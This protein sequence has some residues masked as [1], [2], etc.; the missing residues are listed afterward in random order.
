MTS[1]HTPDR[2][3]QYT[4]TA[5]TLRRAHRDT[6]ATVVII[7]HD[8][9]AELARTLAAMAT[10]PDD[11]P[12]IV[13][14]NGSSD[15]TAHMVERRFPS[16]TVIRCSENAGAIG[17]N[18]AVAQLTT[19]YV[20]FCDDDTIWQPGSLRRA[21]DL[22][23]EH[24]G[25]GSV[26][27]RCLVE[28]DLAEDPLTPELRYSP[29][30]GPSWL[31]GPALLGVMAGLSMFRTRAFREV[32]GFCERMWLGGEEELLAVD[33]AEHGWWMC[34]AEDVI[35]HH[36]P[37]AGRD[38]TRRR[39]LGIRNALWTLWLRRPASS[40]VRRGLRIIGSAPRDAATAR[41]VLEA[42][43]GAGWVVR[44]RAVVSDRVEAGLRQLEESQAT[45][46]AR[47]YVG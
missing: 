2:R 33:L 5:P 28:P 36:A 25:L 26:T 41:A 40:A 32:G 12:I 15:G 31:P 16:V 27:G 20:A 18:V 37:S 19:E 21:A 29:I 10:S 7:T 8:R 23:D 43:R 45:S 39:Q 30:R 35:I 3:A 14:D 22:L 24:D 47:R 11:M 1:K 46:P 38:A 13:V 9:R 42:L 34:W 6:R 44:H 4:I 17:R